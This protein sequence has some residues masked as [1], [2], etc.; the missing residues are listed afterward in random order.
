[1]P[2]GKLP[3]SAFVDAARGTVPADLVLRNARVVN[4]LTGRD[5]R[6]DG[7]RRGRPD[8]RFRPL[9][10]G[11]PRGRDRPRGRL[12]RSRV[13]GRPHPHRV[14]D[15][16]APRLRAPRRRARHRR[17]RHRPARDRERARRRGARGLPR[18]GRRPPR[19]GPR[20]APLVR[21]GDAPRDLG[22]DPRGEGPRPFLRQ[23]ERPRPRRDDE[24]PRLPLRRPGRPRQG[25]GRRLPRAPHRRPLAPPHRPR[26]QRLRRRR[27][28]DRPRV[29]RPRRGDREGPP[30]H[31]DLD[32]GGDGRQESR[33]PPP[34]RHAAELRA[35]RLR[36][37]RPP[38]VGPPRPRPRRPPRAARHR[39]RPRPGPRLPPR[40]LVVRAALRLPRPRGDRP[41]LPRRPPHLRARSRTS[42]PTSSSSAGSAVARG[43]TLL[44]D[45]PSRGISEGPVVPRRRLRR[46]APPPRRRS[47]ARTI[48]VIEVHPGSLAT[49][50][51]TAEALVAGGAAVADPSR[52]LAKLAVVE[53]HRGTGNVGVS[54]A[55]GFG[56]ARGAIAS[57]VAHDSHN[58]VVAGC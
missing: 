43:G 3:L 24:R 8:P 26:P 58:V 45:V 36:H 17:G 53:R 42:G 1:M 46:D 30:R 7:R 20:H 52:D 41:G 28:P 22:R 44:V 39:A 6:G 55:R 18:L 16:D 4:V 54:F 38:P 37:R 21:P 23:E 47:R 2:A 48:R 50:S 14:D 27:H 19:R 13:L 29:P 34:A 5:P 40:L 35:F 32:P 11:L 12:P 31:V 15:D 51:S 33:R 25:R 57:S 9:P 56:L 49:G 10:R